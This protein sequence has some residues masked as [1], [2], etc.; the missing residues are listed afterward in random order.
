M[1]Y[2]IL[3]SK[4]V[5]VMKGANFFSLTSILIVFLLLI[6]QTSS[7]AEIVQRYNPPPGPR[8]PQRTEGS[9]S[10]GCDL[11]KDIN[12]QLLAPKDHIA[13]T[14][15][16]DPTFLW[17][18]SQTSLPLRFILIESGVERPMLDKQFKNDSKFVELKL[19]VEVSL[20]IGKRYRWT[21]SVVCNNK[22]PSENSYAYAWIKRVPIPHQLAEELQQSSNDSYKKAG[23]YASRGVWYEAILYSYKLS[24]IRAD[25]P[26]NDYFFMLLQQVG[27][28]QVVQEQSVERSA[29]SKK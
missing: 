7:I 9:G 17:Y 8:Q 19:P 21:V 22:H 4:V 12:L 24:K 26:V 16:E 27:L 1:K 25:E 15:S 23:V 29:T 11:A 28:S 13:T 10:R 6:P 18:V 3:E 20:Q 14:V 2:K 5:K